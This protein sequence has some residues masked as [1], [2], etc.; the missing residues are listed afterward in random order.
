[1]YIF[2][3]VKGNKHRT[4]ITQMCKNFPINLKYEWVGEL[5]F[6]MTET[7]QNVSKGPRFK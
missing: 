6:F 5:G 7:S 3:L 4:A 2:K 1:M